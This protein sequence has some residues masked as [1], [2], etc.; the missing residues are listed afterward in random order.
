MA[1]GDLEALRDLL[2]GHQA[3]LVGRQI[4]QDAQGVVRVLGDVHG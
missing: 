2:N 1:A 3:L 4:D